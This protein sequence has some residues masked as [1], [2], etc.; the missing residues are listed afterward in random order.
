M[1]ILN[2]FAFKK[3]ISIEIDKIK[4]DEVKIRFKDEND[5][6]KIN[7]IHGDSV[8]KLKEIYDQSINIIFRCS[9]NVF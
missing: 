2:N 7:F 9:R 4:I 6:Y 1:Q 3:V 5:F 8:D